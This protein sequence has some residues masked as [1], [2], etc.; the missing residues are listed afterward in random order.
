MV[1]IIQIGPLASLFAGLYK[2]KSVKHATMSFLNVALVN[3][4]LITTWYS[5]L[6]RNLTK[7]SD[8]IPLRGYITLTGII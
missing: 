5:S 8:K 4:V 2:F 3:I 1:L 7:K 6:F